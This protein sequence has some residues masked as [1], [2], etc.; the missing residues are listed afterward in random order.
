VKKEDRRKGIVG[1][2]AQGKEGRG[3][4]E[5]GG[6]RGWGRGEEDTF[7]NDQDQFEPPAG[8]LLLSFPCQMTF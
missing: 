4:G 3:G 8:S 1:E 6:R 2:E 7:L 5:G